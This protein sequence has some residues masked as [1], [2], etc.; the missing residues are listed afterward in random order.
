MSHPKLRNSLED[1][2][3]PKEYLSTSKENVLDFLLNYNPDISGYLTKK[4]VSKNSFQ[5]Y[6]MNLSKLYFHWNVICGLLHR[7]YIIFFTMI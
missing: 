2:C 1:Y 7:N 3:F 5:N 6:I 4:L